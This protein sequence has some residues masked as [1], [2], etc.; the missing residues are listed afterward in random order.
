MNS[1]DKLRQKRLV[2]AGGTAETCDPKRG[3][4]ADRERKIQRRLCMLQECKRLYHV[5]HDRVSSQAEYLDRVN[6]ARV[7]LL[8]WELS[9]EFRARDQELT[10]AIETEWLSNAPDIEYFKGLVAEWEQ[11][12]KAELDVILG[13]IK[14]Q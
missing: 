1:L 5:A 11:S 9:E 10:G 2:F 6:T 14:A 7:E 13:R 8:V 12:C 4:T 3:P